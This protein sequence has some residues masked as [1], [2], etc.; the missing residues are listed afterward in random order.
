M[1]SLFRFLIVAIS[2]LGL[3]H[4][5]RISA[6]ESVVTLAA[7]ERPPYIGAALPQNGYAYEVVQE[8]FKRKGYRV[9]IDFYPWARAKLLAAQ[10]SVD[11]V[12]P[13]Y[14]EGAATRDTFV[15]SNSFPGDTIGLLK[16]KSLHVSYSSEDTRNQKAL[17]NSL[18]SYRFCIVRDGVTLPAFDT[19][20]SLAKEIV[21]SEIQNLDKLA[22]DR[23][24]FTLID[25]YTAADL[26]VGQ[27]PQLIGQ[28]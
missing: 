7:G 13:V 12:V 21:N 3:F 19:A 16:K 23:I 26:M 24:Q 1:I 28:L 10:G 5:A 18:S 15:Y 2:L 17:F 11:A 8:A 25:K 4:D 20:N 6:A 27:R 22:L 9:K 14:D